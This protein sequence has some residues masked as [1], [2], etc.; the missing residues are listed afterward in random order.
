MGQDLKMRK[1]TGV[2]IKQ[3]MVSGIPSWS[4]CLLLRRNSVEILRVDFHNL[5]GVHKLLI[6]HFQS[7]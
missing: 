2:I 1:W 5:L 4:G 6:P 7:L 3:T